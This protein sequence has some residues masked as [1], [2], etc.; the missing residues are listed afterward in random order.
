MVVIGALLPVT[1]QLPHTRTGCE[2][3]HGVW[4][5][6]DKIA[7]LA[8]FVYVR[9]TQKRQSRVHSANSSAKLGT[10]PIFEHSVIAAI[11]E[12]MPCRNRSGEFLQQLQFLSCVGGEGKPADQVALVQNGVVSGCQIQHALQRCC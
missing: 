1:L 10:I 7:S 4:I 11:V 8:E 5:I 9:G 6:D 3:S 12:K 2:L